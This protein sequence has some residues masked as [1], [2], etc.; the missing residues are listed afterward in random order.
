MEIHQLRTYVTVAREGH[1]T[2]ASELL[3]LSQPALSAHIKSLEDELGVILFDRTPKGMKLTPPGQLLLNQAE[4][5]LSAFTGMYTQAK[6]LKNEVSGTVKIGTFG[7]GL[8]LKIGEFL[9]LMASCYPN[10]SLNLKQGISGIIVKGV[11]NREL[12]AGY[13]L[14]S[15]E[16]GEIAAIRLK[17]VKLYVTAPIAWKETIEEAGWFEIAKIP[18]IVTPPP[19]AVIEIA[20]KLNQNNKVKPNRLDELDHQSF[21]RSLVAAGVGLSIL[22]EDHA[23]AAELAGKVVLWRQ[24]DCETALSFLYLREREDEPAIKAMISANRQVWGVQA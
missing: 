3:N 2:R 16:E 13:V 6:I 14:G 9:P 23:V 22:P 17:Y 18:W 4:N 24:L 15:Y 5:A 10:L 11:K 12:D 21:L 8:A 19:C 7:D 1:L 20:N